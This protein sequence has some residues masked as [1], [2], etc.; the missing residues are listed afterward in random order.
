[1]PTNQQELLTDVLLVL[2][3]GFLFANIRILIQFLRYRS[4]RRSA[5]LVWPVRRPPFYSTFLMLGAALALVIIVKVLYLHW[6]LNK[7]FGESMMLLYYGGMMPLSLKITRGFYEDGVWSDD[8][9]VP[10]GTI[11]GLSW[12]E[13]HEIT[14]LLIPRMRKLVRRLIVPLEYYGE[15]RKLLRDKIKTFDIHFTGKPLD[16][17]A[18]DERDDV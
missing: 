16:L 17:G 4:L 6:G 1:M 11:G 12:R 3:G 15:A 13:E 9:F 10:Y 7:I 5:V 14:L 8:G 2:G 18:H